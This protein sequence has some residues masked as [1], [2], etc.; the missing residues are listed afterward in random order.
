MTKTARALL[1]LAILFAP[2]SSAWAAPAGQAA[3][4]EYRKVIRTYP[5]SDPNPIAAVGRVYP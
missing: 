2:A 1:L 3:V 5:F 4:R